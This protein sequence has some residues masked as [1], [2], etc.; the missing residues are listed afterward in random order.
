M[1]RAQAFQQLERGPADGQW[2][3]FEERAEIAKHVAFQANCERQVLRDWPFAQLQRALFAVG[4]VPL[5]SS[6]PG[7]GERAGDGTR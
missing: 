1:L 7:C 4:R 6:M 3:I 5:F 2:P